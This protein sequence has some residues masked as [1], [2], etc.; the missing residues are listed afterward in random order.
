M[1]AVGLGIQPNDQACNWLVG[2]P[3]LHSIKKKQRGIEM[4]QLVKVIATNFN[5]LSLIADP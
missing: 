5:N 3:G 1:P 2:S 4:A